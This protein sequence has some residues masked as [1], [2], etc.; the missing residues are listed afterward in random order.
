MRDAEA[1]TAREP[2]VVQALGKAERNAVW[3][4][5]NGNEWRWEGIWR[6]T[7]GLLT[8]AALPTWPYEPFTEV[9]DGGPSGR[10][11]E[12]AARPT[13]T[14]TPAGSTL[15]TVEEGWRGQS[16]EQIL[17]R[18]L[19]DNPDDPYLYLQRVMLPVLI[20]QLTPDPLAAGT[21]VHVHN[22][23]ADLVSELRDRVKELEAQWANYWPRLAVAQDEAK[24][25]SH[26][27]K[28]C[29]DALEKAERVIAELHDE[30]AELHCRIEELEGEGE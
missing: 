26:E 11:G 23:D 12:A 1:A 21:T 29:A 3:T 2:R 6:Y 13:H 16:I 24:K 27:L 8:T 14:P 25:W 7:D 15:T 18:H 4:D 20:A 5:C 22:T 9:L 28:V 10:V 19:E 30:K 17:R